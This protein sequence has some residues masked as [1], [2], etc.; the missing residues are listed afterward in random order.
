MLAKILDNVQIHMD[1]LVFVNVEYHKMSYYD[2]RKVYVELRL[3]EPPQRSQKFAIL[4]I[5]LLL[6]L[7][8]CVIDRGTELGDV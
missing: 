6:S 8:W 4:P 1:F 3:D 2:P 5:L 7:C